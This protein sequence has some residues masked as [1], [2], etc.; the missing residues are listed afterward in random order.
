M[1]I[2][3]TKE[4]FIKLMNEADESA[5]QQQRAFRYFLT[6]LMI[7]IKDTL[8]DLDTELKNVKDVLDKDNLREYYEP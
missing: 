6:L 3:L 7:E 2:P 4:N 5:E 1:S 8:Q